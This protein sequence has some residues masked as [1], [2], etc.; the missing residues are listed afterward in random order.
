MARLPGESLLAKREKLIE[1][2]LF[3]LFI[4][5]AAPALVF[6]AFLKMGQW[7]AWKQPGL[8]LGI[9][10]ALMAGTAYPIFKKAVKNGRDLRQCKLGLAG[11]RG[12]GGAARTKRVR[13]LCVS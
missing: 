10:I 3:T 2:L 8:Q 9:G 1:R 6:A 5:L 7:L 13:I 11:E 4:G 12:G